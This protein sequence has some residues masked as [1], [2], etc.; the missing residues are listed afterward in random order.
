[1]ILKN[2]YTYVIQKKDYDCGVAAS[3]ALLVNSKLKDVKYSQLAKTL[4]LTKNGVSYRNIAS[5]FSKIADLKPK[6]KTRASL[7]ELKNETK[8]GRLVIVNYQTWGK[9]H[10]VRKL[11]C[12]HYSV[13]VKVYRN[14]V[15]LLDPAAHKDWGDGLGWRVMNL[16]EFSR[17]W[18]DKEYGKIVKRWMVSVKP[19]KRKKSFNLL[20]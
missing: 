10:E 6:I 2:K 14:K 7:N 13:V 15:Y 20:N 9:P 17:L 12:G 3:Y 4:K 16:R 19:L 11:V 18:I 8:K 5:Y 1:M